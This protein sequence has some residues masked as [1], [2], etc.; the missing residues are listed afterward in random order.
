MTMAMRRRPPPPAIAAVALA[1]TISG[2]LAWRDLNRRAP[3]QVRGSK[4]F[5]R[6]LI[7]LN[8]GNSLLYWLFG[9]R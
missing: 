7:T 2:T 6:L 9:R 5:W 1:A 8:P 3:S 4:R